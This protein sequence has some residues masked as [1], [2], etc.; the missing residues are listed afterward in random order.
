MKYQDCST[1]I[2]IPTKGRLVDVK[3]VESWMN[4]RFPQN[5][6]FIR[7]FVMDLEV[8]SAYSETIE[9]IIENPEFDN[10]K[11]VLTLESD[12]LPPFDGLIKLFENMDKF[13]V[14]GG[15][16]WSK[17]ENGF[18]MVFGNTKDKLNFVPYLETG[19]LV[20]PCYGIGMGFTLFKLEIF[21]IPDLPRPFFKT[22]NNEKE[23]MTQDLYFCNNIYKLGYKVACDTRVK[24]GHIDENGKVW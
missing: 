19:D 17:G 10:F 16:Y 15:L 7:L 5:S 12:N 21:R 22:V 24:V 20:Q 14:I 4:L 6:K 9:S 3:A 2:I 11:Y 1:V 8:G 23:V 18:P 13:D